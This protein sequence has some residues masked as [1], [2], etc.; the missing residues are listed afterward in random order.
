M[1]FL[2]PLLDILPPHQN[3]VV[4]PAFPALLFNWPLLRQ[5]LDY[6]AVEHRSIRPGKGNIISQVFGQQSYQVS[7]S[8][9][10]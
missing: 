8:V 5:R 2:T 9:A 3:A 7:V 6:S 10:V 1:P 4:D